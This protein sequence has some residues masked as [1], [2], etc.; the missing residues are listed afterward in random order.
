AIISTEWYINLHNKRQ[1]CPTCSRL[2]FKY[3]EMNKD[4]W[5]D[6]TTN[7]AKDISQLDTLLEPISNMSELNNTWEKFSKIIIKNMKK[8]IPNTKK[9]LY[10]F[11]SNSYYASKLYNA[12]KSTSNFLR[13]IKTPN[14]KINIELINKTID[15]IN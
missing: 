6:Y 9:A 4:S 15:D 12:L 13:K 3:E 2:I 5:E 8:H 11:N 10:S 1:R 7:I 14:N